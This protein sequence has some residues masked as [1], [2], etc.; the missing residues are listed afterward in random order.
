MKK[1]IYLACIL[2][3]LAYLYAF[4]TE[5]KSPTVPTNDA[6][7][8]LSLAANEAPTGGISPKQWFT[9]RTL[10]D[11]RTPTGAAI[12]MLFYVCW[13]GQMSILRDPQKTTDDQLTFCLQLAESLVSQDKEALKGK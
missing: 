9:E 4:S 1:V 8:V 10:A 7:L 13:K 12:E 6:D 2:G 11:P 5:A 3:V